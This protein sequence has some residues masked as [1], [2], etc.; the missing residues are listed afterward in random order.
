MY[1]VN[2]EII[3]LR[4]LRPLD[5]KPVLKSIKKTKKLL[6]VDNGWTQYGISAEIISQVTT[7]KNLNKNIKIMR[8]GIADT[9]IPSTRKLA[10][11]CY[12]DSV[13]IVIEVGKILNIKFKNISSKFK[14]Y[15]AQDVPNKNFT[16]PF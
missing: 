1:N 7:N 16:G 3:D 12:P 9:P 2:V 4:T 13:D 8:M 14:N 10:K 11:L 15:R 6:V 5:I